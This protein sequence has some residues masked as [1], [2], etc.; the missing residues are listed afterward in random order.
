MKSR[1]IAR[2]RGFVLI[3]AAAACGGHGG[4]GTGPEDKPQVSAGANSTLPVGSAFTLSAT[5]TDS[6]NRSPW[7][8]DVAWG[9]GESAHGSKSSVSAIT[10]T[11]T[12]AS[13]GDYTVRV[14]VTNQAG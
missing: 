5:F 3:L 8:Y 12:Y 14:T 2:L 11:H 4:G 6:T 10:A 1:A 13:A 7:S 9:D